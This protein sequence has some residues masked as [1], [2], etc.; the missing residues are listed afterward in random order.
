M[1]IFR[2][3]FVKEKPVFT[4]I[5][6]GLGGFGFGASGGGGSGGS[7]AT[8]GTIN[9]AGGYKYHIF[10]DSGELTG[11]NTI[12]PGQI[13]VLAIAGGGA[14]GAYYGGGGG[15]GGLVIWT[16]APLTGVTN[17][18]IT[19]GAGGPDTAGDSLKVVV[20][21]ALRQVIL[22][23]QV[24]VVAL[25]LEDQLLVELVINQD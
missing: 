25:F 2:D 16:G 15:A 7:Q 14:G 23:V 8:G 13:D 22:V 18:T 11:A 21:V 12:G 1:S 24:V 5:T 10:F 6:R 9:N 3:F 17:L 4:G 19:V 20:A